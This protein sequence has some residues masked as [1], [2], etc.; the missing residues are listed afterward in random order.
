[1]SSKYIRKPVV[2]N[3]ESAWHMNILERIEGE[4]NNFSGYV[5][6]ILKEHFDRKLPLEPIIKSDPVKTEKEQP[7]S[8]APSFQKPVNN[9]PP[10][11]FGK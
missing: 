5:M 1:M 8:A 4:S 9:T 10:K 6:S 3:R 7:K 11:L 2:F